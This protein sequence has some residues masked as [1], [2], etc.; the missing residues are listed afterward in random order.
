M[1]SCCLLICDFPSDCIKTL[2]KSC[3]K[4][5]DFYWSSCW[6]QGL[7]LMIWKHCRKIQHSTHEST[8]PFLIHSLVPPTYLFTCSFIHSII[9]SLTHSTHI[10]SLNHSCTLTHSFHSHN[11]SLIHSLIPLTL[12]HSF[13]HSFTLSLIPLTYL[14][15]CSFIHSFHSL[16]HSTNTF[17]HSFHLLS[18]ILSLTYLFTHSFHLLSLNH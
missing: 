3:S 6:C 2:A 18:F 9:Y 13:T 15:N 10:H 14:F 17:I 1:I 16:T 4:A 8:I 5:S 11:H 7:F 12:I